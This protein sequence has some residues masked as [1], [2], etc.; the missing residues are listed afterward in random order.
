MGVLLT[1]DAEIG[2]VDTIGAGLNG[3]KSIFFMEKKKKSKKSTVLNMNRNRNFLCWIS[4]RSSFYG[5]ETN[6][7]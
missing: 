2:P 6:S 7:Y 3:D 4:W 1:S 5:T